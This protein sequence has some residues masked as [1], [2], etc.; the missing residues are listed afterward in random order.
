MARAVAQLREAGIE[1]PQ[2]DARVLLA[3]C[4]GIKRGRL[5]L[6]LVDALPEEVEFFYPQMIAERCQRRPVSHILKG[7]EFYGRWFEVTP[8][9]LDPR[10][11][12]ECLVAAALSQPFAEVLDLGT[13]SGAIVVTLLAER[14]Q[15]TGVGTDISRAAL[16]VARRNAAAHGAEG[17]LWLT[18]ADWYGGIGG[19]FDLIV[20]NPPYIAAHE[21]AGLAPELS[22]EPRLAL[23]DEGDGLGAYRRIASGVV[24]YL[25]PGGRVLLEIGPMQGAAVYGLLAAAGLV[26]IAVHPDLD[27]RDRVVAGHLP[28]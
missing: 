19:R 8:D 11:E 26:M 9:V 20:S 12:T 2:L 22:H 21:M 3:A 4:S 10:P 13:G 14:V 1:T 7:R 24:D 23:T 5:T 28:A 6:C 27:G 25:M 18:G 16:K 15:A 17:R